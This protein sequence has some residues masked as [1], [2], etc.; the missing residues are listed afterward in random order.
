MP[1]SGRL[2]EETPDDGP[3]DGEEEED[4]LTHSIQPLHDENGVNESPFLID[5]LSIP[6][7]ESSHTG[8]VGDDLKSNSEDELCLVA[9]ETF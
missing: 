3:I 5:S 4:E 8:G 7:M 9:N 6:E 1:R 2:L